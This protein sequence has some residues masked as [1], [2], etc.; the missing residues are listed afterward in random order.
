M[1]FNCARTSSQQFRSH[2]FHWS[3][4]NRLFLLVG[5]RFPPLLSVYV[6]ICLL[7]VKWK[8]LARLDDFVS[9]LVWQIS[10]KLFYN[11]FPSFSRNTSSANS[12]V[13]VHI[14]P[15]GCSTLKTIPFLALDPLFCNLEVTVDN[16][17]GMK[18]YRSIIRKTIVLK[19]GLLT[20]IPWVEI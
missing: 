12:D 5:Y 6:W 18:L 3:H 14:F 15:T 20:R 8:Y 7:I 4:H 19:S 17:L 11:W 13:S 2:T 10:I 16:W 1:N 9:D